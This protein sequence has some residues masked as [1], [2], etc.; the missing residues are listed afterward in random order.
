MFSDCESVATAVDR[1]YPLIE[2]RATKLVGRNF[3]ND[4]TQETFLQAH[5]SWGRGDG[6]EVLPWLHGIVNNVASDFKRRISRNTRRCKDATSVFGD[7]SIEII[8]ELSE[9]DSNERLLGHSEDLHAALAEAMDELTRTE[10]EMVRL[11]LL[12]E[13][14]PKEIAQLLG[15]SLSAVYNRSDA[16]KKRLF[17]NERLSLLAAESG[18]PEK[19]TTSRVAE[20]HAS[21]LKNWQIGRRLGMS[22]SAVHSSLLRSK[23]K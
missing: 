2:R 21:G 4:V 17:E 10:Q 12:E 7:D 6:S 22:N 3:A 15:I 16:A 13:R 8:T 11:R 14:D 20:L 1:H 9:V 18:I 19:T 5:R 23:A